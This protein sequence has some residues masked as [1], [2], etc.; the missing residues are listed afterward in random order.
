MVKAIVF[1]L[2]K[3]LV[4]FDY[5]IAARAMITRGGVSMEGL[6][7]LLGHSSL[8]V[9]YE[10]GQINGEEF[11]REFCATTGCTQS[12]EEFGECFGDIFAP[13]EPMIELQAALRRKGFPTYVFSNTNDLATRVIRRKFPFF[14]NFDGYVYSFEHGAMKPD[15]KLYAVLERM[16][17]CRGAELLYMDDRAENVAAG[18]TRGWQVIL[19]ESP[20]K[21]LAAI[22]KMGLLR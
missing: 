20:A 19:Q 13:I 12:F 18:A 22:G 3:V 17:G 16:A 5:M 15:A 2:G 11:Y 10:S 7:Q 14:A 6:A 4:D 8:L 9:R 21:T 1:D